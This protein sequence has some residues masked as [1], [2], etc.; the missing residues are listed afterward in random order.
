MPIIDATTKLCAIIGHPITHSLSPVMH[1]A[2]FDATNLNYVYI[3]FDVEQLEDC[4]NGMR[5]LPSFRGMSV[6]LP[7]K[8]AVMKYLDEIDPMAKHVGS[9]N[10]ITNEN[11]R[12][13]GT[14]TD[15]LG[16]LRAFAEAGVSLENKKILFLGSGGAVRAAAFAFAS[17]AA[18]K[19]I[20]ILGRTERNVTT[21]VDDLNKTAQCPIESAN[22]ATD[23]EHAIAQHDIIVNGTPIG[24][25]PNNTEQTPIPLDL[26]HA[27]HIVFDMVYR[28]L[29]TTLIEAA[30]A[31]GCT[32]ILGSEMLLNQAVLQFE[33]W[34]DIPAPRAVMQNA[35]LATLQ[36]DHDTEG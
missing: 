34:T 23:I 15:G 25:Y 10:T 13:R 9:V 19:A 20:T 2:A 36:S 32:T 7:H 24:M 28:P 26:L 33:T 30:R 17:S 16:T 29:K 12:L 6:T 21:L 14:T 1:N 4:L 5:A 22:F 35:L 11:G 3:A 27:D 8:T 18:P 31:K